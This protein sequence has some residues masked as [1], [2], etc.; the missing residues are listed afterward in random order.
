MRERCPKG[1]ADDNVQETVSK[2]RL[3]CSPVGTGTVAAFCSHKQNTAL[4]GRA[5]EPNGASGLS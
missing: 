1:A 3:S 4:G 5:P 2:Y